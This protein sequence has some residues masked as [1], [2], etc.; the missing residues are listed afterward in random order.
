MRILQLLVMA[1][2]LA[3]TGLAQVEVGAG[4][5]NDSV[6]QAFIDAWL[7]R[8]FNTLVGDPTGNVA[9]YGAS[10]YIQQFPAAGGTAGTLA[11]IK[12]DANVTGAV[13]QVQ[14]TMFAFFST[15]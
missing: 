5:P 8:G 15:I 7:R 14:A 11:L 12:A 10:G 13:Y 4:A 2:V 3:G 1:G 6:R 9:K